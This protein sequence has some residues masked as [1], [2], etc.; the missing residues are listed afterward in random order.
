MRELGKPNYLHDLHCHTKRSDGNDEPIELIDRAR[1]LGMKVVAITDHDV[2][3]PAEVVRDGTKMDISS[4]A[5][6]QGVKVIRGIEISCDTEVEDVHLVA[7]GCNW[8]DEHI[9]RL[10]EFIKQSKIKAYQRLTELLCEGGIQVR[11]EEVLEHNGERLRPEDVQKKHI[12]ELIAQ[13]GYARSWKEAKLLVRDNPA[14]NVKR[15]KPDPLETLDLVHEAGGIGILAHPHLIDETIAVNGRTIGRDEYID[16]LVD[17]GL[18]GIEVCYPYS[19][20]SYKGK[21]QDE[22]IWAEVRR[23]YAGVVKVLSGGSDYHADEK[24]GIN[25]PRTLG[26][27]GVDEEYFNSNELLTRLVG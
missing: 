23:R 2:T 3:P 16:R 22:Q 6:S 15:E 26:E 7:F 5:A 8:E 14:L 20:T 11:W 17:R 19:K 13:K 27:C 21:M 1:D 25:N 12:F 24:K 4:Y 18:E 9:G 10:S